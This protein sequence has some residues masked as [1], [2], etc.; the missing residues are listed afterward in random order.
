MILVCL[1]SINSLDASHGDRKRRLV[2]PPLGG[3]DFSEA[4][5][6]PVTGQ[7]CVTK[8]EETE[9]VARDPIL[10]CVHKEVE[11]CHY[12]YVTQ[13]TPSQEQ[14]CHYDYHKSCRISFTS[15]A[16]S[17]TVMTCY[18][19]VEKVCDGQGQEECRTVYESSC[20]TRYVDK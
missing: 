3:I 2:K 14:V 20:R 6:D 19:P 9:A 13:F 4:V 8:S 5:T 18:R 17:E 12:T 15:K 1:P 10:A 16:V 11:K 7:K